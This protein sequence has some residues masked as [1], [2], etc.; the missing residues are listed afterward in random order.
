MLKSSIAAAALALASLLLFAPRSQAAATISS[1]N[2][3]SNLRGRPIGVTLIGQEEAAATREND[4]NSAPSNTFGRFLQ[5]ILNNSEKHLNEDLDAHYP[6][7][8]TNNERTKDAN[9]VLFSFTLTAPNSNVLRQAPTGRKLG[10][11]AHVEDATNEEG[12]GEKK[13]TVVHVTYE[14]IYQILVFLLTATAF[15]IVTSKLGMV[16]YF[17]NFYACISCAIL[18]RLSN[19]SILL[20]PFFLCILS[21]PLSEKSSLVSC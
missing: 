20:T 14:E 6:L 11:A 12:D 3:N 2:D 17:P 9:N 7:F 19:R 21:P 18:K 8:Q 10:G 16:S 15:G 5:N 13:V 4:L 1:E